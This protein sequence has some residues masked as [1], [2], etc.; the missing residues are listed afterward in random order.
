MSVE[1]SSSAASAGDPGP[2]PVAGHGASVAWDL[3]YGALALAGFPYLLWRRYARGKDREGWDQKLGRVPERPPHPRRVW[4]HAVSVGE[5]RAAQ[6]LDAALRREVP[7]AE[8]V[9]S[10]TTPTGQSVARDLY[11]AE[12]VFYYPFDFSRSVRRALDR[13]KPRLIVL[14]ELEVWPNLTAEAVARGIPVVV[15]NARLTERSAR[16]YRRAWAL[17]G[18]SFRRVRRWLAQSDEYAQRLESLGVAAERI[19]AAGNIKYDAVETKALTDA[20]RAAA[21]EAQ[22]FPPDAR[23]LIG[24]STH[25]GEE[26]ALLAAY[27]LLRERFPGLRL[28]LTPRHPHRLDEVQREIAA[29]GFPCVRRSDLKAR[30]AEAYAAL[31]PEDRARAVVLVDT[32]GE[33]RGLYRAAEVAFIGGSLIPHGGQNVMEPAGMGLPTVYGPHMHNFAEAVEILKG[34]NGSVQVPDAAALPGAFGKLFAD[35]AASHALGERARAAFL[36]RQGATKRCVGYLKGLLDA[37]K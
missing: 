3:L 36:A 23:V 17:L 26:A 6:V 9:F 16:N 13:V 21:R 4:I 11:G 22:G 25:P 8:V 33:L 37:A 32:M 27:R 18:P 24:G 2:V 30:G 28:I 1:P 15:V 35:P 10:T 34:C 14:M 7:G 29:Q 31:A 19:E 12:R 20:E 5:A